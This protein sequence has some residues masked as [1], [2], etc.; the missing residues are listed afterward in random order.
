[1][2]TSFS[3]VWS[4]MFDTPV[5]L[6][7]RAGRIAWRKRSIRVTRIVSAPMGTD[8]PMGR[9]PN[10]TEKIMSSRRAS[11]NVGVLEINRQ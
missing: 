5:M 10:H 11:Q 2:S 7:A 3:R 6:K 4:A 9:T 1:M 8:R